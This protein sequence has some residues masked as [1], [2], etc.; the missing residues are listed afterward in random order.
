MPKLYQSF[1]YTCKKRLKTQFKKHIHEVKAQD[2][3]SKNSEDSQCNENNW[4]G[5]EYLLSCKILVVAN[6]FC[7]SFKRVSEICLN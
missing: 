7:Q 2:T 6:S 3:V 5:K 1:Y 4:I